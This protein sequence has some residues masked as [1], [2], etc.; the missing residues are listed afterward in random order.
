MAR[1]E[2]EPVDGEV[3]GGDLEIEIVRFFVFLLFFIF[4]KS[5]C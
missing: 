4:Y 3:E 1:R 5:K 2:I